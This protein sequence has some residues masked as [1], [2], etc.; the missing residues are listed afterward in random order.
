MVRNLIAS[1]TAAGRD[2]WYPENLTG[3]E[4]VERR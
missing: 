1:S 2:G 4:A 3:C